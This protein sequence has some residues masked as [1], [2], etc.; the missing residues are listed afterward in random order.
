M[1]CEVQKH[2]RQIP[3]KDLEL[4]ARESNMISDGEKNMNAV[5]PALNFSELKIINL[6]IAPNISKML[7]LAE[8]SSSL[9]NFSGN[10]RKLIFT[11]VDL[12]LFQHPE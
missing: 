1:I 9:P 6:L 2:E 3:I 4:R 5:L 12:E 8:V 10:L 7:T 11:L